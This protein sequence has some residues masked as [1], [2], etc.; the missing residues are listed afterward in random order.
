MKN[1]G[2]IL[3]VILGMY[4]FKDYHWTKIA[5]LGIGLFALDG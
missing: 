4:L 5:I 1:I 2:I 3:V